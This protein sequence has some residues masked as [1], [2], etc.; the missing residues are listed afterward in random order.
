M[1]P[2]LVLVAIGAITGNVLGGRLGDRFSK[3]GIFVIFQIVS[4][5]LGL[6]LFGAGLALAPVVALA[7]LLTL[8]NSASRPAFLAYGSELAP[9]QRAPSSGSSRSPTRAGS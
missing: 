2:V 5:G 9:R 6:T 4:A 8:C 3:P 7:I 1:A